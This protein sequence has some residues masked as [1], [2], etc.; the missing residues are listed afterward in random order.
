MR[1]DLELLE[2]ITSLLD[3][4]YVIYEQNYIRGSSRI[5]LANKEWEV[6]VRERDGEITID[7]ADLVEDFETAED[8]KKCILELSYNEE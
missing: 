1:V 2:F 7:Y 8:A 3:N 6:R 5:Y 4:S